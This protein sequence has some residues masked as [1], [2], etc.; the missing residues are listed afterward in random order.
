MLG[1]PVNDSELAVCLKD[2]GRR[3]L[4]QNVAC[5]RICGERGGQ[6]CADGCMRELAVDPDQHWQERGCTVYRNRE[7][8]GEDYDIALIATDGGLLTFLQPLAARYRRSLARL[9][10]RGLTRR[11]QEVAGLLLRGW[12][13]ARICETL[14]VS[15]ATLRTH[16][17]RIYAKLGEHGATL[18]FL[19][20]HRVAEARRPA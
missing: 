18:D 6:V 11:E 16:L 13:N 3:V 15:R 12:S 10:G 1:F 5:L 9:A 14:A 8:N 20:G 4:A 19:P 17:N 7:I 2:A